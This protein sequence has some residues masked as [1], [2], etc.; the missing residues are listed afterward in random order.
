MTML[1]AALPDAEALLSQFLR[2]QD[3]IDEAINKR[4]Y[5]AIPAKPTWPLVIIT[6]VAGAP[7]LSR[8][9]VLDNPTIQI[10]AY[11]GSKKDA[12]DLIELVRR[13]IA[14]RIQGVHE[15]LGNVT[16]YQFGS[17]SYL[18]DDSYAPSRPRYVADVQL[19]TK[20]L[21]NSLGS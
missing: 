19:F 3:E 4:V 5:T 12:H 6:R 13:I 8:P 21:P 17:M 15:D 18:P 7:I 10:D 1:D 11:G 16:G 2:D 20:P 14:V 9:L